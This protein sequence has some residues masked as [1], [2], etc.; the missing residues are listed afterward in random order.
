MAEHIHGPLYYEHMGREGPVMA[1]VHPNPMDQS[2]WLYQMTHFSTW[3]RCISIDIPGYGRSPKADPGLTMDDMAQACWEAVD[4][5][6]PGEDAILVGCSTGS[7][8]IPHMYH[9]RPSHT[10]ALIFSGTGYRPVRDMS[11]RIDGYRQQGIDYRW[12]FTFAD[13][14]AAFRATP[15]AHYFA[16]LFTE[17]NELADV[18]TIICQFEALQQPSPDDLHSGIHCPSIILTGSEDNAHPRAAALQERIPGC[19]LRTL[20]GA[21]H[22]CYLEQPRLFDRF[23]LE[24]LNK[25]SLFPGLPKPVAAAF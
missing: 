25:H 18:D 19:E 12:D 9:L 21:G 24:F 6:F 2:C 11:F 5:A 4:D 14:S 8:I 17:R 7:A 3:Y 20:P 10:E 16:E 15:M 13:L 1:F 23:M 22:A